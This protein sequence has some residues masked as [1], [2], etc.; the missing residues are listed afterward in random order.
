MAAGAE[1]ETEKSIL[2]G[3]FRGHLERNKYNSFRLLVALL[4]DTAERHCCATLL[5]YTAVLHCLA[6]LLSGTA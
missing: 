5:C 1:I 2:V 3:A 6:T 4:R